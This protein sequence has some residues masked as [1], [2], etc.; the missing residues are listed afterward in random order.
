MS[1]QSSTALPQPTPEN[2][3]LGYCKGAWKLQ[4]GDRKAMS[5]CKEFND[6][7][8]QSNVYYLACVNSKCA[9]S[10]RIN[11][12]VIWSKVWS[13]EAKGI[14]LRWQF[15][16]KSHVTQKVVKDDNFA[17]L[18]QF[19]ICLGQQPPV[20]HGTDFY[21]E[22]ISQEHR[23]QALSDVILF[24]T[25]CV[26]DRICDDSEDFDINLMPLDRQVPIRKDSDVLSDTLLGSPM[27]PFAHGNDSAIA[28]EQ[29][30]EGLSDF[31][32]LSEYETRDFG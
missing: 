12:D 25:H 27:L 24:R 11:L 28:G 10:G 13:M 18:C 19:C 8:S 5:R 17:Y 21:I 32:Y 30:N 22:H 7:W 1:G 9:F 3:Y 20:F 2:N 4:N 26:N 14:K 29:W 6:G 31:H 23:G 16:A 15:L